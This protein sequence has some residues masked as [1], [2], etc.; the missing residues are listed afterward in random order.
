MKATVLADNVA[1]ERAHVKSLSEEVGPSVFLPWKSP[2]PQMK[3]SY[4]KLAWAKDTGWDKLL[5]YT[6]KAGA[7]EEK[8]SQGVQGGLGKLAL[9]TYK[10]Y[11]SPYLLTDCPFDTSCSEYARLAIKDLGAW[12]GAKWAALRLLSC[13]DGASGGHDLPPG[14][15]CQHDHLHHLSELTLA[16]PSTTEKSTFRRGVEN[17]LF[18]AAR[19]GGKLTGGALAGMVG[20]VAGAVV[21]GL[22]GAKAGA[23]SLSAYNREIEAKYGSEKA[24]ALVGLQ[25]PITTPGETVSRKL[26]PLL[27][28]TVA[29]SLGSVAGALTGSAAGL[30]GGAVFSYRFFGGFAGLAAQNAAKDALGELPVHYHT[31]Q[32]LESSYREAK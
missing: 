29:H 26:E 16:A 1:P 11:V 4:S 17:A 20:G 13:Q 8:A 15:H 12:E 18:K 3:E 30:F 10:K 23:G 2:S 22:W 28:K 5:D 6:L 31:E 24:R 9:Y 32:I 19:V 25:S 21:G 27:G 14:S 7:G